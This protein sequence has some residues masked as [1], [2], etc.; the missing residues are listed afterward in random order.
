MSEDLIK[1]CRE[2]DIE[3]LKYIFSRN[4]NLKADNILAIQWAL[5][6]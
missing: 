2:G 5:I 4:C 1:A 6:I 3:K